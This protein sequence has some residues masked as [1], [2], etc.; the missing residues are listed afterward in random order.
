MCFTS[1]F[2]KNFLTLHP[3]WKHKLSE[4]LGIA[5]CL[6][7]LYT[8]ASFLHTSKDEG[9]DWS[10]L[11]PT[12]NILNRTAASLVRIF[13]IGEDGSHSQRDRIYKTSIG[14]DIAPPVVSFLW[15]AHKEFGVIL[16]TR[17]VCVTSCGP[18]VKDSD[19][20][21]RVLTLMLSSKDYPQ[22]CS[23]LIISLTGNSRWN[24]AL[25]NG[26][27]LRAEQH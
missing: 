14:K 23:I 4:N 17:P 11:K 19:L 16:P 18:L 1:F 13:N 20:T 7:S 3:L 10:V 5:I 24:L 22:I 12:E 15:I 26:H 6:P 8:E 2:I 21:S 25:S 27:I 9:V